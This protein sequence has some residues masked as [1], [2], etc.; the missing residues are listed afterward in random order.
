MKMNP[1]TLSLL[2]DI[3]V[4]LSRGELATIL[5]VHALL[6]PDNNTVE[7]CVPRADA[8]SEEVESRKGCNP[9]DSN[10]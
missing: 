9:S 4:W 10:K 5:H 8:L 6:D 1:A 7:I 2:S 3:V